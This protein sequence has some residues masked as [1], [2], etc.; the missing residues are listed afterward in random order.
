M[1]DK[2]MNRALKGAIVT[3]FGSQFNFAR[4]IG[5]HEATVS[6]IIRGRFQIDDATKRKW[7]NA[8]G[9]DDYEK[10]FRDKG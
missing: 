10:L 3:R 9:I 1:D 4:T 2:K 7:A 8:L 5:E 6:R